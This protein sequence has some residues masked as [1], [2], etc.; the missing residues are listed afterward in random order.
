[1]ARHRYAIFLFQL[2]D[3]LGYKA[4]YIGTLGIYNN[5]GVT[6]SV[7]SDLTTPSPEDLHQVLTEL[8]EAGVTHLA[9][10]ASSHGLDQYRLHGVSL[11]AVGFTNLLRDHLDYHKDFE[12]YFLSKQRL[13]TDFSPTL[14]VTNADDPYSARLRTNVQFG[15]GTLFLL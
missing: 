7:V 2:F 15:Q 8:Y 4:A 10:E 3:L 14:L 1:M 9:L 12:A 6:T 13:F 11:Y 5:V